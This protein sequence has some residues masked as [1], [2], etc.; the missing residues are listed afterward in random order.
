MP[1]PEPLGRLL[2]RTDSRAAQALRWGLHGLRA[3][4]RAALDEAPDD[5]G[6][7]ALR[8]LLGEL[9]PLVERADVSAGPVLPTD[10]AT[11]GI[12]PRVSPPA[13]GDLL[14]LAGVASACLRLAE[15]D[16]RLCHCLRSVFQFGVTP[17]AGDQRGRYTA[18]LLRL[19]D[20]LRAVEPQA[21]DR[22]GWKDCL[23]ACLDFDEAVHSLVYPPPTAPDPAWG[24]LQGQSREVLGRLRDRAVQA[25]CP[26]HLQTLGG[27]FAD[28]SRLAP[29]SL[30]VDFGVPG[31]VSVCLRVWARLDGE[32]LKGRVLYRSP[33]EQS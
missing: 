5:P 20:R 30:Q 10:S 7:A 29:D 33:Q 31:E 27:S 24:R 26:V 6:G 4:L 21:A 23:K 22:R 19:W 25:G 17:M 12:D 9:D 11:D 13:D 8:E 28:V 15:H 16:P 2:A 3:S 32:E 1:W 14:P 18:E